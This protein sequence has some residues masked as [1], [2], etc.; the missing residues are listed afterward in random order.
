MDYLAGEV[1]VTMGKIVYNTLRQE[2]ERQ[3]RQM[4]IDGEFKPG[5]RIVEQDLA[6][7]LGISRGPVREALRK[8]EQE[9]LVEYT[10]NEGCSVK[11]YTDVDMYEIYLIRATLECLAIQICGGKLTEENEKRMEQLLEQMKNPEETDG[12]DPLVEYDNAF[13]GCILE[14]TELS[15]INTLWSSLNISNTVIF[16]QGSP[17]RAA[18]RARMYKIHNKL[19]DAYKQGDVRALCD[20]V[21]DHYMLTIRRRLRE[22]GCQ[23]DGFRYETD[24]KL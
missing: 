2:V 8:F 10:R 23:S 20:E 11:R 4:V 18:A 21:M 14:Q 22:N 13:H 3:I 15:R 9:G 24:F 19:M 6:V 17:D 12:P 16:Y 7:A 5:D 1:V